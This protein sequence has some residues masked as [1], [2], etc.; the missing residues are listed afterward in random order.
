LEI[1]Q[2]VACFRV[3]SSP[4]VKSGRQYRS[5]RSWPAPRDR[6]RPGAFVQIDRKHPGFG[7][8]HVLMVRH[9][10]EFLSILPEWDAMSVGLNAILL[11]PARG[12]CDGFHRP[13]LVAICAQP[14]NLSQLVTNADYVHR[15]RDIF[16]RLGVPIEETEEGYLVHFTERTLRAYQLLHVLLHE[17]GHHHDRMT[18]RSQRRASRGEHFAEIYARSHAE[19]VWARY[20]Q[21]NPLR[22]HQCQ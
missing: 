15:H 2:A 20:F 5:E 12:G 7:H 16:D 8:R 10:R 18:T 4:R 11:A 3:K 22:E 19:V 21:L 1:E 14:R 17:L 6:N 13:G 9:V